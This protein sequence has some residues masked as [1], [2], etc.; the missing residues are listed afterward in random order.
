MS[1]FVS[2]VLTDRV[3]DSA[4]LT[5]ERRLPYFTVRCTGNE[6][7]FHAGVALG[8]KNNGPLKL[9]DLGQRVLERLSEYAEKN[10]QCVH[11]LEVG[12][13]QMFEAQ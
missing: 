8:N 10:H 3:I 4:V 13:R 11:V 9:S 12:D 2:K 5:Q 6:D 1:D 7:G